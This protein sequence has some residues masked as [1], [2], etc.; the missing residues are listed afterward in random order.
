MKDDWVCSWVP[1]PTYLLHPTS[2][3]IK[4]TRL[5]RWVTACKLPPLHG[6]WKTLSANLCPRIIWEDACFHGPKACWGHPSAQTPSHRIFPDAVGLSRAWRILRGAGC[7]SYAISRGDGYRST[8]FGKIRIRAL[9]YSKCSL[10]S[11]DCWSPLDCI[12]EFSY[13]TKWDY[14]C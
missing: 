8:E 6:S 7:R 4:C 3:K 13:T 2:M 9:C 14:W 10:P 5:Q 12:R 11:P 1:K